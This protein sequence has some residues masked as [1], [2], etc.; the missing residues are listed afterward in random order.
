MQ[1]IA[2][3]GLS[4]KRALRMLAD[5]RIVV[6]NRKIR[7]ASSNSRLD[8]VE[9]I[10]GKIGVYAWVGRKNGRVALRCVVLCSR[11]APTENRREGR[12]DGSKDSSSG[13][14]PPHARLG[15]IRDVS[16]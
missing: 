14:A 2:A 8:R 9:H 13:Q 6:S 4:Q 10:V 16:S 12:A 11:L 7:T 5:K 1:R 15:S 3:A